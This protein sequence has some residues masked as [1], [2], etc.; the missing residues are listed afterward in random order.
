[1]VTGKWR[2]LVWCGA[3][4]AAGCSPSPPHAEPRVREI[5]EAVCAIASRCCNP[6]ELEYSLG[7]FVAGADCAE[8][9]VEA[10]ALDAT[11]TFGGGP[12]ARVNL[13]NLTSLDRA[14]QDGRVRLDRSAVDA[15]V[16]WLNEQRCNE[17]IPEDDPGDACHAPPPV[18]M[19]PCD[20]TLLV[21]GRV[22]EGG[23]CS[24]G[25]ASL[26][27]H[28][29]LVCLRDPAGVG[30]LGTCAALRGAGEPCADDAHCTAGLYCSL[31]D[32]ACRAP[33]ALGEACA[34]AAPADP[35]PTDCP[36]LIRCEAGLT[37]SPFTSTC[38]ARCA[39]GSWCSGVR[40]SACGV[41]TGLV[42]IRTSRGWPYGGFCDFPHAAG[43]HCDDYDDCE[44][45]LL[46][47][48]DP[49]ADV[50][51]CRAKLPNGEPCAN[52]YECESDLCEYSLSGDERVCVGP[53]ALGEF[54]Y[55][56]ELCESGFCDF[57]TGQCAATVAN[58][59]SCPSGSSAE[60][61][62]GLCLFVEALGEEGCVAFIPAG[63]PC[64]DDYRCASGAC[65]AGGCASR[66]VPDGERCDQH[67]D[68]ESDFCNLDELTPRCRSLPLGIGAPC[69]D[70]EACESGACFFGSCRSGAVIGAPCGA[71]LL[72]CDPATSFC[73]VDLGTPV[74]TAYRETGES[75]V[76]DLDCRGDCVV[77]WGRRMCS[78]E[79]APGAAICDGR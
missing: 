30:G 71:E 68:C 56:D 35:Q 46:C 5:A 27:C 15:C 76:R 36:L 32:G 40:E 62:N 44:A 53:A 1:M 70:S 38:V 13:P 4:M 39:R 60:C 78:D 67:S 37:C 33:A 14:I 25:T 50:S 43:E 20:V 55:R 52:E 8:R 66:P 41:D 48:P 34:Y 17:P 31:V 19:S 7:P 10:A 63:G 72:P 58:G 11:A 29:G 26:E 28:D 74:C 24:G 47:T 59:Q 3:I 16:A 42:C 23:A 18:S 22:P 54:C 64:N 65:I 61:T 57:M 69:R 6:A 73:D 9:M 2:V 21:H 49:V 12:F 51:T 77:A 79:P 45:P 75:C